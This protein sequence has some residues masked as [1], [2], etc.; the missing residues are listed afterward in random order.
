MT[1]EVLK[2]QVDAYV[3]ENW[4]NIIE[5]IRY[6]VQVESV[7]DLSAAEAGK[8]W[9][10]KSFEALRRGLELAERLGLKTTNV[11]GYLGFGDLPGASQ[12]YIATIAHTDIVPLGLG[13]TVDPL[14]VTRK[15]GYLLGR[16]V[17]DDKGPFVLSLWAAHFFVEHVK[18]TGKLLPYTLRAIVGNNEETGMGDVPYYLER[19]P[20]PAFCFTPDAEFPLICGEKGVYHGEF[21]S[22]A[23]AGEKIVELDG[24]T[25]PNAI[26][27]L[28]CAVVRAD[29]ATLPK[30]PH[31][32]VEDAGVDDQGNHLT[33]ISAHGKGGHASMPAGTVNAIGLLDAYL[34]EHNLCSDTERAF[35]EFSALLCST[36]DGTGTNI[37]SSDDKFG[38][39][40]CISGTVRTKNGCFAQTI[41]SRYPTSTTGKAIT[42]A[43]ED[44]GK[45]YGCAYRVL[46]DDVPFYIDPKSPEIATLLDTYHEYTGHEGKA[47]VIGGGTYARHFKHAVAFGPVES[48]EAD[49]I[50]A[51]V[52]AEHG[53]DEGVSEE[54]LRRALKIYIVSIARLME[55][56]L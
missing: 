10:P 21:T 2:A 42:S 19:Y 54:W 22:A 53:P 8:P 20:E 5:D 23:I 3:D 30:A 45:T 1:D 18:K 6:L 50:P 16:G 48:A 25:V 24:G 17:L 51:W 14:D 44:L 41:D 9:G 37:Q 29:A 35:L 47:F 38:P 52:G 4:E 34:L 32:D 27:G 39:L 11:D 26:P 55:L 12:K 13:W 15:D 28:A 56:D 43:M 40:T 7:E 33:R 36:T 46:A 31:I 49:Q